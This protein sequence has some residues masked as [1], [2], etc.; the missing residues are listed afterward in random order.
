MIVAIHVSG[1]I[2]SQKHNHKKTKHML[3]QRFASG[4]SGAHPVQYHG[5]IGLGNNSI[6]E[7]RIK[8][9]GWHVFFTPILGKAP[10]CFK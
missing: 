3:S 2:L 1:K 8:M 4:F 7:G 6:S 9:G 5:F 10:S